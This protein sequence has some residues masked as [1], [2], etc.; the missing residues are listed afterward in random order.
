[1]EVTIRYVY[2]KE[3]LLEFLPT[4]EGGMCVTGT[5]KSCNMFF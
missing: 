4:Q 1:M 3:E 2:L 5:K